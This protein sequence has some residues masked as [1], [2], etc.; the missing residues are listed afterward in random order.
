M[1]KTTEKFDDGLGR[2]DEL[3][4]IEL[5]EGEAHGGTISPAT[6][7]TPATPGV[8]ATLSN[9]VCPTARVWCK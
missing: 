5:G 1:D 4:L 7:W 3:E 6:P 9:A 2:H 8:S